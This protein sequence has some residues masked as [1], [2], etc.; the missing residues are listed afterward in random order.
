MEAAHILDPYGWGDSW[1]NWQSYAFVLLALAETLT[2]AT[3]WSVPFSTAEHLENLMSSHFFFDILDWQNPG[4]RDKLAGKTCQSMRHLAAH[5]VN[6]CLVWD[7]A[8]PDWPC[9]FREQVEAHMEHHFGAVKKPFPSGNVSIK[10]FLTQQDRLH[11]VAMA[12]GFR[13][14]V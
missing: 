1:C 13:G 6:R 2:C 7:T 4:A 8:M 5:G 10:E 9:R 14:F 3:W 11:R 12:Q